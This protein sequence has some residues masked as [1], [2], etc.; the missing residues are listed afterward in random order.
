LTGHDL[1]HALGTRT[2]RTAKGQ[3]VLANA[4]KFDPE[5]NLSRRLTSVEKVL[6]SL[7]KA[8]LDRRADQAI[9]GLDST[10]RFLERRGS[11]TYESL[12]RQVRADQMRDRF[13]GSNETARGI[14]I[15]TMHRA[16]GKE[17]DIA[18]FFTPEEGG[19]LGGPP[20]DRQAEE[21]DC[22]TW[23]VS[24]SRARERLIIFYTGSRVSPY[25]APLLPT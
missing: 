7:Y 24:V 19:F 1:D 13:S 10:I 9:A 2:V 21:S 18:L 6:R 3:A 25:L 4:F 11:A 23:H 15:M 17:F 22:M 12:A 20:E 5:E 16:K 14:T 8:K